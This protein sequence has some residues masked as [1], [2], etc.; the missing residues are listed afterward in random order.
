[1]QKWAHHPV[2]L[3]WGCSSVSSQLLALVATS[4]TLLPV[5]S[6]HLSIS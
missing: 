3:P 4:S 2:T 6:V 5:L 1:M